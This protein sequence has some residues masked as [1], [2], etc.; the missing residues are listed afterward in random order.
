MDVQRLAA[1]IEELTIKRKLLGDYQGGYSLGISLNSKDR[2]KLA[3][4]LSVEDQQLVD[5]AP[6]QLEVDGEVIPVEIDTN[7][8]MSVAF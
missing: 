8:Q 2:S 5:S 7:Y 3:I 1:F 4:S 6:K